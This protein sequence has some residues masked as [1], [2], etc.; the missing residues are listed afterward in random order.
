MN[1]NELMAKANELSKNKNANFVKC[2]DQ[3][4]TDLKSRSPEAY[5]ILINGEWKSNEIPD[6][7]KSY[8][9]ITKSRGIEYNYMKHLNDLGDVDDYR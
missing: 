7:L 1:I 3:F 8:F 2:N 9:K 4:L 5:D 6:H